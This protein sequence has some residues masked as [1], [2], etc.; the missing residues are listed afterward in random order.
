MVPRN[1][2]ARLTHNGSE[3]KE[4]LSS[5]WRLLRRF[6]SGFDSQVAR[7]PWTSLLFGDGKFYSSFNFERVE[8]LRLRELCLDYLQANG[9]CIGLTENS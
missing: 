2:M 1:A 6:T 8:R 7:L 3:N 4:F 5:S 9:D